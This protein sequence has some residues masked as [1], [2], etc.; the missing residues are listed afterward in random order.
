[1][2][3]DKTFHIMAGLPRS[4]STMLSAILNQNPRFHSG[5][6]SPVMSTMA[7]VENFLNHDELYL[8][9]PKEFFL[10]NTI[11]DVITNY[12]SDTQSP[13]VFD[14]NRSWPYQIHSFEKYIQKNPKIICPV[15]DISEILAS[16]ISLIKRNETIV[17]GRLNFLD[18]ALVQQGLEINDINRCQTLAGTGVLGQSYDGIKLLLD[19]G[20]RESV[21]FVEY[22]DLVSN[23]EET[24]KSLYDFLEEDYYIHDFNNL[25]NNYRE[26]DTEQY[27]L[28]D[29]HEIRSAVKSTALPPEEVLPKKVI[30]DVKGTEFWREFS[31]QPVEIKPFFGKQVF[32]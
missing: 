25:K 7:T 5:P 11:S 15:R 12:Y 31:N 19:N 9:Y 28:V 16:F 22:K 21:H 32:H 18:E 20:Y 2:L 17:N 14:K 4:G 23:T 8:A 26:K 1:M 24:I 3:E 30:E 13:I 27:R 6:S 29:M 10:K